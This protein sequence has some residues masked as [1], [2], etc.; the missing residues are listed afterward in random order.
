MRG[1]R[2]TPTYLRDCDCPKARAEGRGCWRDQR[3][4]CAL[5]QLDTTPLVLVRPEDSLRTVTQTLLRCGYKSVPVLA[6]SGPVSDQSD[7]AD[8]ADAS[9]PAKAVTRLVRRATLCCWM[10]AERLNG[11]TFRA[12]FMR[13]P[14]AR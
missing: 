5:A 3:W 14:V 12:L 13:A 8:P 7:A 9:A 4:L 6:F 1:G 2:A 10:R 11:A